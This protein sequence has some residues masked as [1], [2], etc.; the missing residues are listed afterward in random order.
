MVGGWSQEGLQ[1]TITNRAVKWGQDVLFKSFLKKFAEIMGVDDWDIK[2]VQGEEND[3]L[4]ELQRDGVEIQNMAMLQQ[5]G[6]EIERTHSGDFN[7]SKEANLDMMNESMDNSGVNGRGRSTAAPV[8]NRQSFSGMPAQSRPSD[9]GGIAQGSPSSGT[10][11]SLSQKNYPDGI[12]PSNFQVVKNT[13]QTAV[14]YGWKKTKTVDELRK[15]TG[16]TVR[17]ARDVVKAEFE[18]MREWEEEE[19][20]QKINKSKKYVNEE[21]EDDN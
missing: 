1:V 5:M 8:E 21:E 20:K 19:P 18:G 7:V 12:T 3:K 9:M 11:S 17:Q 14:D 6:F 15:S 2:L 4:A 10:G 16:M 13:L